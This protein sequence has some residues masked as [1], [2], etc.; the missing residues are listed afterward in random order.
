MPRKPVIYSDVHPYHIRVR[1]N[2]RN[3]F[4]LPPEDCFDVF[5]RVLKKTK[6]GYGLEIHAFVMMNNHVHMI[7]S[8]PSA[9]ISECMR[10][11]MT[12]A[13]RGL[14]IKTKRINHVF[15]GRYK[16]TLI[17][18]P[19]YYSS[20][21]KYIYRNPVRADITSLVELY[22]WSNIASQ[23]SIL[24]D[25]ITKP[26]HGHDTQINYEKQKMLAWLNEPTSKELEEAIKNALRRSVFKIKTNHRTQRLPKVE[27]VPSA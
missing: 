1:S 3:W 20:C 18:D 13:S 2:N 26:K 17:E 19:D 22:A 23:N 27:P 10:Y 25:L 15:G 21:L 7:A 12:E 4:D 24:K 16:W 11:F 9:N 5:C 8:T 14:R 6:E